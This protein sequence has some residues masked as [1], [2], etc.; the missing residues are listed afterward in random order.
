MLKLLFQHNLI[1]YLLIVVFA[2]YFMY[3][4]YTDYKNLSEKQASELIGAYEAM[5]SIQLANEARLSALEGARI[6]KWKEGHNEG[7]Y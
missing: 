2:F 1:P 7:K 5:A 4:K 6:S 3:D